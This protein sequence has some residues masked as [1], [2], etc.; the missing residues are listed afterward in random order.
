MTGG[1]HVVG[2]IYSHLLEDR[3]GFRCTDA[4]FKSG[5]CR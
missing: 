4:L 3:R 5:R 2:E 1:N